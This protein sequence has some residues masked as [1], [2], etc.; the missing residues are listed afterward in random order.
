VA[1]YIPT[2]FEGLDAGHRAVVRN[3]ALSRDARLLFVILNSFASTKDGCYISNGRLALYMGS[4]TRAVQKWIE[5]LKDSKF[6]TISMVNRNRREIKIISKIQIGKIEGH[7]QPFMGVRTGVRGGMNVRSG[8]YEQPFT[9]GNRVK[10]VEGGNR[11]KVGT[12]KKQYN[13]MTL[14]IMA[15][16][17]QAQR[18]ELFDNFSKWMTYFETAQP[19]VAQMLEKLQRA[20]DEK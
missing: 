14:A 9:Q 6:I 2:D 18:D 16:G 15:D 3:N 8:G 13:Y 7:E 4:T 5:E 10:V 11:I 17:S 12:L 1:E 19:T 20:V